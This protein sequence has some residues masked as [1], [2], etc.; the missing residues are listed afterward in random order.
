M[1]SGDEGDAEGGSESQE[2]G[3]GEAARSEEGEGSTAGRTFSRVICLFH[4]YHTGLSSVS[5][6]DLS[7]SSTGLSSVLYTN[8]SS[9]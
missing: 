6:M 5:S 3:G 1:C 7:S 2:E 4:F 8:L 9:V